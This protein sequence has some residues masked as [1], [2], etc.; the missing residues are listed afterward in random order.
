MYYLHDAALRYAFFYDN[1][2]PNQTPPNIPDRKKFSFSVS[3]SFVTNLTRLSSLILLLLLFL[4]PTTKMTSLRVL[5]QL[6]TSSTRRHL[7]SSTSTRILS[8]C[9]NARHTLLTSKPS[10]TTPLRSF[11]ASTQRFGEGTCMCTVLCEA[12]IL[13][14]IMA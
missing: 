9:A 4:I 14:V 11:S 7:S 3:R 6:T 10:T 5:R 2:P 12:G 13:T 8:T 1:C